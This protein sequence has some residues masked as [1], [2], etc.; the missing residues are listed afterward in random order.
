MAAAAVPREEDLQAGDRRR[1]PTAGSRRLPSSTEV[2]LLDSAPRA[3]CL[4]VL[5]FSGD[6]IKLV[7]CVRVCLFLRAVVVDVSLFLGLEQVGQVCR[8][9]FRNRYSSCTTLDRALSFFLSA[10]VSQRDNTP[11]PGTLFAARRGR[12]ARSAIRPAFS[13]PWSTP[14][15]RRRR[16]LRIRALPWRR[17][18]PE[19]RQLARPPSRNEVRRGLSQRRWRQRRWRQRWG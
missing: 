18:V 13:R 19:T 7:P 17:H 6:D 9:V 15:W 4:V 11:T 16:R 1:R 10:L 8:Q 12:P 5:L 3:F 14:A 2:S